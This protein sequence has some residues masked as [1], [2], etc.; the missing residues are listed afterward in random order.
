LV[1]FALGEIY[2]D[3][4]K[5]TDRA[6]AAFNDALDLDPKFLNA[7]SS[8]EA[9]LGSQ[10]RWKQ[11]EEN[12]VR[13]IQRLPKTPETHA[14]R[15]ALWRALGELYLKILQQRDAAM[16]AYQVVAAGLPE[17][18]VVQ[19]TYADLAAQKPGNEE[20]AIIAYRRAVANTDNPGRVCSAFA[21]L[22]AR[23]KDYDSAYLAAEVVRDLIGNPGDNEK[24]ILAKLSPYAKNKEVAQRPIT[25]QLWQTHL[26]H[27]KVRG[28]LAEMMA[29][30][31][32]QLGQLYSLPLAHYQ[33]NPKKHRIDVGSAQEYQIHHYR[34]VAR[35]LGMEAIDLYS[36]FLVITRERL[37][38]RSR[39]PVPEP[40]VGVEICHTHPVC[41]KV[42]G[43]FFGEHGQK[44][45]YYWLGR[46]LALMRP[47]LALSQRLSSDRLE[48][49]V[50]AAISLSTNQFAFTAN[51][52]AIEVE[53][54][55]LQKTLS[56][57]ARASLDRIVRQYLKTAGPR[58][59][60]GLIEGAELT[61]VRTGLFAA[62]EMEPV[63]RM[64]VGETG[65]AYRVTSAHKIREM[66]VFA[67]S[68]DLHLLRRAVGTQV[69]VQGRKG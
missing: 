12:Y 56:E 21:E 53:R 62:G 1:H 24:E 41:L 23:R 65:A 10:N 68:E 60:A 67:L 40:Q 8:I 22:S 55:A 35:L 59:V 58:D 18:A 36:P 14:P 29:L 33:L 19:E 4:V 63:K 44:E 42:G 13:M 11:L 48:A 51:R 47:E 16:S 26:F 61:A 57:P 9:L 49:L 54:A 32:Q 38:K 39:D 15:M 37:A 46:A 30:L 52:R 43:K 6:V 64:V 69:E 20:H 45:V 5:E 27:P 3:E 66:M 28:P 17:D 25:D 2:R 34:Y 31:Y 50:Q 7:F